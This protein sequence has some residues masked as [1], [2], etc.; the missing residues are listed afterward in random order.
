M[1]L[2]AVKDKAEKLVARPNKKNKAPSLERCKATFD[3]QAQT[4]D[5]LTIAEG[6]VITII[7]KDTGDDGWWEGE[8]LKDGK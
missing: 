1:F 8:M 7:T 6:D 4:E 5:E 3:Y 2:Q